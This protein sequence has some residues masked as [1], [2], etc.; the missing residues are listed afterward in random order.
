M[1]TP[2][3][4]AIPLTGDPNKDAL[5]Q[6]GQWQFGTDPRVLTYSFS[7]ETE[8]GFQWSSAL[9][10][11]VQ[12]AFA[13]YSAVANIS[14]EEIAPGSDVDFSPAD[15]A[16]AP[17]GTFMG[18]IFGAVA[19][20]IF[21]DPDATNVFLDSI[22]NTREVY[23][24]PEGDIYLDHLT[25]PLLAFA[26]GASAREVILH[27]IG[28]ALGLK[29]PEDGG[30]NDRPIANLDSSLTVMSSGAI[31]LPLASGHAITP[32]LYDILAIQHIYGANMSYNTGD[33]TYLLSANG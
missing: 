15:I 29:H 4:D 27:E 2:V 12:D 11:A 33:T 19:I 7:I 9:K 1:A 23:P 21:P 10:L 26:A 14:F 17:T 30:L 13:A 8:L 20:G 32:L 28:H 31:E 6:G 24:N 22:G 18:Q 5:I 25:S 3:G 16:L